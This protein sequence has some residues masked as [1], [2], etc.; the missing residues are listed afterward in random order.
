M[1]SVAVK[2]DQIMGV[3][4]KMM[5]MVFINQI[6]KPDIFLKL[7][8][9]MMQSVLMRLRVYMDHL[10]MAFAKINAHRPNVLLVRKLVYRFAQ[11]HLL[12]K[13]ISL[14]LNIKRPLP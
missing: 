2:Q 11:Q 14:I 9:I 1:D 5:N 10:K 7:M 6:P 8:N 13:D 12:E 3:T 4:M